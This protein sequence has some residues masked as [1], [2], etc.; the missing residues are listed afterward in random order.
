MHIAP[1]SLAFSRCVL[2]RVYTYLL[3]AFWASR[4][5]ILKD[6]KAD[7][8]YLPIACRPLAMVLHVTLTLFA[9]NFCFCIYIL[10]SYLPWSFLSSFLSHLLSSSLLFFPLFFSSLH[11]PRCDCAL[12]H[13]WTLHESSRR[14]W[15]SAGSI[16]IFLLSK[17]NNGCHFYALRCG[18]LKFLKEMAFGTKK[19]L[20]RSMLS[21]R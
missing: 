5:R 16:S 17:K 11:W 15:P 18:F 7:T 19:I 1:F 3:S 21:S 4:W 12:S 9:V 8:G 20:S 13:F 6:V 14:C 10:D 2:S